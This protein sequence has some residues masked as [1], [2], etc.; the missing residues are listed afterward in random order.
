[1]ADHVLIYLNGTRLPIAG[2]ALF[3]SLADY[4]RERGLVGTKIGCAEGDC[5]ACTVL[6]GK[7][8]AGE[9]RYRT[10]VSC[11]AAILSA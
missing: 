5:G 7:P 2:D 6:V 11:L 3:G 9:L 1:M 4:L 10:L 8:A